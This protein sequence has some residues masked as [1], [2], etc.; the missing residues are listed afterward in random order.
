MDRKKILIAVDSSENSKRAVSYV[1]DLLGD[2]P[3]ILITLL[4]IERPPDRDTYADD[5]AWKAAAH[6][7]EK[8][9]QIFL[10][11]ARGMLEHKGVA[12]ERIAEKYV[13]SCKSGI[14]EP[15]EDCSVGISIAEEILRVQKEGGF[16]TIVIGRRGVSRTEEF[17]YGSV[18][19]SV[20]H[21]ARVGTIWVVE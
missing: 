7:K 16:G 6:A 12:E 5:T 3:D 14:H 13:V 11:E 15:S 18:S 9:I 1:G 17:L 4:Y 21:K 20:M 19:T 2:T 10:D 8:N